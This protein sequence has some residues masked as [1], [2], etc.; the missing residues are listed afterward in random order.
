M[1][2]YI[3]TAIFFM[4][5]SVYLGRTNRKINKTIKTWGSIDQFAAV[6]LVI[7]LS[8]IWPLSLVCM[9][10]LLGVDSVRCYIVEERNIIQEFLLTRD[11][12]SG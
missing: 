1:I 4:V 6:M 10:F 8:I 3:L 12:D 2:L 5:A 9:A 7:V 11:E